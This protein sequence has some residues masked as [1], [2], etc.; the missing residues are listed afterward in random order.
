MSSLKKYMK[1]LGLHFSRERA[2]PGATKVRLRIVGERGRATPGHD[3]TG[4]TRWDQIRAGEG[5]EHILAG[6]YA[7][8]LCRSLEAWMAN[9]QR[10]SGTEEEL[11]E[12]ACTPREA[13]TIA[14]TR[15]W[16]LCPLRGQLEYWTHYGM[17][18]KLDFG[19]GEDRSFITCV[20]IISMMIT[21]MNDIAEGKKG[22]QVGNT[23]QDPCRTLF[24]WYEE[25][26]DND[27]AKRVMNF[28]FPSSGEMRT[29]EGII[30]REQSQ[31]QNFWA[32]LLTG[33]FLKVVGLQCSKDRSKDEWTTS[34]LRL[35]EDHSCQAEPSRRDYEAW[36][37]EVRRAV[38]TKG[39]DKK[40]GATRIGRGHGG[41]GGKN[42]PR[43]SRNRAR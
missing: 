17:D 34:C 31:E 11:T 18:R 5:S 25:W 15:N 20:D 7:W 9:L 33:A 29:N 22:W 19:K 36:A 2:E 24:T 35:R 41:R 28:L 4:L 16:N 3:T 14:G 21:V 38:T 43:D 42:R 37:N 8:I 27:T 32:Q 40:E 30:R 1:S 26:A 23:E 12:G 10:G 39:D 13:G 6:R